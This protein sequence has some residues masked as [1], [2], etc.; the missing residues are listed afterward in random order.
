VILA[1]EILKKRTT[2]T[3]KSRS[4]HDIIQNREK[5]RDGDP[6]A[7]TWHETQFFWWWDG[8]KERDANPYAERKRE[9][10]ELH[11]SEDRECGVLIKFRKI[12]KS[13][14]LIVPLSYALVRKTHVYIKF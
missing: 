2:T 12:I 1:L 7:T 3:C 6:V 14:A 10:R 9:K 13:G 4:W 8:E 11:W 5:K